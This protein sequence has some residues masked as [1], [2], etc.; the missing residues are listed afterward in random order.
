[1][2]VPE[3]WEDH[4]QCRYPNSPATPYNRKFTRGCSP[5]ER[6]TRDNTAFE[7]QLQFVS[8]AVMSLAVALRD[9]HADMCRGQGLCADMSPTKGPDLLRYLRR[10]NFRGEYCDGRLSIQELV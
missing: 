1:M 7:N 8:D 9:M 2:R 4:F 3:F 10:V 5:A 6:L